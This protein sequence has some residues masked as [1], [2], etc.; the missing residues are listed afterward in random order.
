M[1][2]VLDVV[3]AAVPFLE[4]LRSSIAPWIAH[5]FDAS[6]LYAGTGCVPLL[7]QFHGEADRTIP[8]RLGRAVHDGLEQHRGA[9]FAAVPRAGHE[10]AFDNEGL[11][12]KLRL[13][14]KPAASMRGLEKE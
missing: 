10:T 4:P 9:V 7:F 6:P 1:S 5:A 8:L 11:R 13:F 3:L 12:A 2:S 14:L